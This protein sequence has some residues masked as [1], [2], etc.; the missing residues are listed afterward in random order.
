MANCF[1]ILILR[2]KES[3]HDQSTVGGADWQVPFNVNFRMVLDVLA[4]L[5]PNIN[6]PP[7][8]FEYD[9]EDND[10]ITVR[11]DEELEALLTYVRIIIII[12]L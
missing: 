8:A 12:I 1:P 11:S 5:L 4:H 7:T 9:D 3:R 6:P 2:I 10:C